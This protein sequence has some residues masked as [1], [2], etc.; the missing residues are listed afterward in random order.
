ADRSCGGG[1]RSAGRF[2]GRREDP[3]WYSGKHRLRSHHIGSYK[4]S[5]QFLRFVLGREPI[6]GMLSPEDS[7]LGSVGPRGLAGPKERGSGVEPRRIAGT[8]KGG[9]G[10]REKIFS[11]SSLFGFFAAD[12]RSERTI[13]P[14]FRP[15]L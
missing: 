9:S 4:D 8:K 5:F 1:R 7:P 2:P 3:S 14:P 12:A 6:V 11:S 13:S 15:S 10:V